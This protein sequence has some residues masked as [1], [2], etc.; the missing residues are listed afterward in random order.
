MCIER[1]HK[2][3][4]HPLSILE[5]DN[6]P[7]QILLTLKTNVIM[8][9]NNGI[10]NSW[11]FVTF[12]SNHGGKAFLAP[13][14]DSKTGEPF[15][16][17]V[18]KKSNSKEEKGTIVNFSSNLPELSLKELAAQKDDL[19]VVELAVKPEVLERRKAEG[20]QLESYKLCRVGEAWQEIDLS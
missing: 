10:I 11:S 4:H 8:E 16:S 14:I 19:Q 17:V 6:P 20:K 5:G 9:K 15:K 2:D 3:T 18:C 12:V 7:R 1:E 13:F